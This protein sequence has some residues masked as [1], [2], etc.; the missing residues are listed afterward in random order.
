[1]KK[2]LTV[3]VFILAISLSAFAQKADDAKDALAV[4]NKM[5]A[6]M[7]NHNPASIAAL[8]TKESNL[9]AIIRKKDGKNTIA[10]FTGEAFS[11]SFT[12]RK[13]EIREDMYAPETKVFGDLALVYGRYVFFVDGKIS[14]CGVNAFHL[15]RTDAGWK[16]ANASSTIDPTDCTE[17][18]K[19]RKADPAK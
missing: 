15:V 14:H 8:F 4:V 3:T 10:A 17:K 7:A 9:T 2:I 13:N 6:E 19:K 11:K 16:I 5:F 18:E 12:E 1:M